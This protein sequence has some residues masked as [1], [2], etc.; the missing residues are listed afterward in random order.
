MRD[1]VRDVILSNPDNAGK[2][3]FTIPYV[4]AVS[5]CFLPLCGDVDRQTK[6]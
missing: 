4:T 3:E 6:T 2:T 1:K 5:R